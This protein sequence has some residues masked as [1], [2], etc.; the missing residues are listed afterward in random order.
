VIDRRDCGIKPA[1]MIE[2]RTSAVDIKRRSKLL[3]DEC[4]IDIF[5]MK[6][7]VAITKRM[8]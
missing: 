4:K 3:S 1:V 8:H 7:P 2:N 5:A 6:L